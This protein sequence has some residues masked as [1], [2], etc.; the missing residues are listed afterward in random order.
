MKVCKHQV[1]RKIDWIREPKYS[2]DEILINV[3]AISSG[4]EHYFIK[5]KMCKKYP[6]WF[7]MSR[8]VIQ[9]SKTQP[10]GRGEVYV[11]PMQYAQPLEII[12]PCE[13]DF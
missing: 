11:V 12:H 10:N 5:F 13:H 1:H 3:H 2:T 8:K 7:Y 9:H 4:I 6:D